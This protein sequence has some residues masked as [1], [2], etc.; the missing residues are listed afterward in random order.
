MDPNVQILFFFLSRSSLALLWVPAH[1]SFPHSKPLARVMVNLPP[2]FSFSA[3]L[4]K[5]YPKCEKM[6]P[7]SSPPEK[8]YCYYSGLDVR[9]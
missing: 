5:L 7:P 2:P 8:L 6:S 1:V 3:V 9:R 4:F